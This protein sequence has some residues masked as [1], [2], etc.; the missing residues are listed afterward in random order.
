MHGR[1]EGG[2]KL[3][4]SCVALA[5][6]FLGLEEVAGHA[7]NPQ[8]LAMLRLDSKGEWPSSD[9]TPWCSALVNYIAWLLNLPR[10]RSLRARSWLTVGSGI[11]LPHAVAENDVVVLMRGGAGQPGPGVLDAPGHV[12]FFAGLDEEAG[13]VR[14]L[15]GNQADMVSIESFPIERVLRVRRLA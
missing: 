8:I 4:T 9:E 13:R 3:Q 15:G 12:G 11:D 1:G 5:T 6:R 7:S 10:S 14:V 2:V